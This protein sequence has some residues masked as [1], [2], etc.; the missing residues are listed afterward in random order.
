MSSLHG[1]ATHTKNA[2]KKYL[3][4]RSNATNKGNTQGMMDMVFVG[5]DLTQVFWV[6]QQKPSRFKGCFMCVIPAISCCTSFPKEPR[7]DWIQS[8]PGDDVWAA[9]AS[10]RLAVD[11]GR[12]LD[13]S[14]RDAHCQDWALAVM[15]EMMRV[16]CIHL[17]PFSHVGDYEVDMATRKLWY[18]IYYIE[19]YRICSCGGLCGHVG[20]II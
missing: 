8:R 6:G 1:D 2:K 15:D 16:I 14:Q 3:G 10:Q 19:I 7:K 11:H 12:S 17:Y 5:S 18:M 4:P 9:G 20:L 13:S